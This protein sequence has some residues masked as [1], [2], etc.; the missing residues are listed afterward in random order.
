MDKVL[1]EFQM[2]SLDNRINAYFNGIKAYT[3]MLQTCINERKEWI[4][5]SNIIYANAPKEDLNK[6]N[7]GLEIANKILSIFNLPLDLLSKSDGKKIGGDD[8][9]DFIEDTM[10]SKVELTH[11]EKK[12]IDEISRPD[13]MQEL[14]DHMAAARK[15]MANAK[16]MTN[17]EFNKLYSNSSSTETYDG[18]PVVNLSN[19]T[20][21]QNIQSDELDINEVNT[22][23]DKTSEIS[24]IDWDE[25]TYEQKKEA[26][27]DFDNDIND[28]INKLQCNLTEKERQNVIDDAKVYLATKKLQSEN[29][30]NADI[31]TALDCI[32]H[33]RNPPSGLSSKKLKDGRMQWEEAPNIDAMLRLSTKH[34]NEVYK[35]IYKK[36]QDNIKELNIP[37][38]KIEEATY[39]EADKLLK[40]YKENN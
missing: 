17:E 27:P 20:R 38:E 7:Q 36:A 10:P 19:L 32:M 5:N 40:I 8:D 14:R 6:Y 12:I 34:R 9:V 31:V 16:P 22:I 39:K 13:K 18:I 2:S 37:P 15:N 3:L 21:N 4:K 30:S 11:E 29:A 1:W 23:L 25:L 33:E 35:T 24:E 28:E 26:D